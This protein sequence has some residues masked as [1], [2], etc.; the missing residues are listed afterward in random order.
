M[1]LFWI[2]FYY[3]FFRN[4][5]YFF[6]H[7]H[8]FFRKWSWEGVAWRY[9]YL[10]RLNE[11]ES[12]GRQIVFLDEPW[13]D[14]HD[15]VKKGWNDGTSNCVLKFPASRGKRIMVLHTRGREWWVPNC[16]YFSA[17]N[18]GDCK[19]DSQDEA[20]DKVFENLP[21][22]KNCNMVLNNLIYGVPQRSC[23]SSHSR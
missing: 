12:Q 13:Y 4:W 19:E 14:T 17:K 8:K 6:W 16:L 9:K 18:I 2:C 10:Q 15:V 1:D 5:N 3:F 21:R 22:N 20:R 7:W 23:A 11:L